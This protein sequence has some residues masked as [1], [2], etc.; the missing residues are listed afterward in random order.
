GEAEQ[1]VGDGGVALRPEVGE[2]VLQPTHLRPQDRVL[3]GYSELRGCD[4]VTE[5]GLG[6]DSSGLS[7]VEGEPGA[8]CPGRRE[9][10]YPQGDR[11]RPA[12][13]RKERTLP[14]S[15][16]CR[17]RHAV[18]NPELPCTATEREST[19]ETLPGARGP[20]SSATSAATSSS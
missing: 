1:L 8:P 17:V 2:L 10:W 13:Q 3:L 6:H 16:G 9:L 11:P 20:S 18:V 5:Q 12:G 15:R 7:R 14:V 19:R 4:D